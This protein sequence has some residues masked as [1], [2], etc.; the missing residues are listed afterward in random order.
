MG[1]VAAR[2]GLPTE[3]LAPEGALAVY[4]NQVV[5]GLDPESGE[6]VFYRASH[7]RERVTEAPAVDAEAAT[8]AGEALC[9]GARFEAPRLTLAYVAGALRAEWSLLGADPT[10]R[11]LLHV[12]AETAEARV[13]LEQP[14][15]E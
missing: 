11:L 1:A 4:P 5:V 8:L 13:V 9:P 10:R 3:L 15:R 6:V 12:D 14:L 7:V 2:T